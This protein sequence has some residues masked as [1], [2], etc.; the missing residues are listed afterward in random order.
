MGTKEVLIT[1]QGDQSMT[2]DSALLSM[3]IKEPPYASHYLN[4]CNSAFFPIDSSSTTNSKLAS[5][6]EPSCISA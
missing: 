1:R 2:P 6:Q 4:L 3:F 5:R